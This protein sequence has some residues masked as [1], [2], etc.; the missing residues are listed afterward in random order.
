ML[1]IALLLNIEIVRYA[2]E[3]GVNCIPIF[4][5]LIRLLMQLIQ[6]WLSI[7]PYSAKFAF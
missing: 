7:K 2:K 6:K 5:P 3:E 1:K 4:A